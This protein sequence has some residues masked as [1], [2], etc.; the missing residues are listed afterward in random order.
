MGKL[1]IFDF[2]GV[3]REASWVQMR[4]TY[5]AFIT[6]IGKD[7]NLFFTDLG[8]FKKWCNPDWHKNEERIF[9]GEYSQNTTLNE[10]FHTHYD[11]HS[12]LFP[13]V[14]E[15]LEHLSKKYQLAILSSSTRT[16]VKGSLGELSD[17]FS[18]I[19]GAEEVNKLKPDPE[20]ILLA[21]KETETETNDA[22]IIGDMNVD[23]LAGKKA[24][25]KVGLVK[26][27]LGEWGELCSLGADLLFEEPK[28]LLKL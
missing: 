6:F 26:W 12:Q 15:I 4:N 9:G 11:E 20:G 23:F 14:P 25:I 19:I 13:W 2:D 24:G 7:P 5:F 17:Y 10:F 1:I 28:E 18:C 16:S 22:I 21:L 3:L 8:S 27:G